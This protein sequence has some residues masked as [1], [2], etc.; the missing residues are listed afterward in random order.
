ARGHNRWQD[1]F[2]RRGQRRVVGAPAVPLAMVTVSSA[3]LWFLAASRA[4]RQPW[5]FAPWPRTAAPGARALRSGGAAGR[6]AVFFPRV[7]SSLRSLATAAA[8]PRRVF[9]DRGV[10]RPEQSACR[11]C[12]SHRV[13]SPLVL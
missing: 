12:S 1:T 5:L 4:S 11:R 8:R 13:A 6:L 9:F 10:L 3:R 7:V 2:P